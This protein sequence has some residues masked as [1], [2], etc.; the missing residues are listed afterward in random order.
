MTRRPNKGV[1][2]IPTAPA[3]RSLLTSVIPRSAVD[4]RFSVASLQLRPAGIDPRVSPI[5][6]VE[7]V[8]HASDAP[9]QA[10]SVT[11]PSWMNGQPELP[12]PPTRGALFRIAHSEMPSSSPSPLAEPA[13]LAKILP[14]ILV[15]DDE[16]LY[17]ELIADVL[18]DDYEILVAA[19]GITGL[20]IAA[21]RVPHLILLDLKIPGI[22]GFE[23]CKCLK[24]DQR[25]CDIA[26]IFITGSGDVAAETKG[27]QM[28]A[29]DYITKPLNPE[30]V[31]ARVNMQINFKLM[32][33]KL[34]Q[35]AAT[36]GLTGLANRF[37]FDNMLAYEYD[38][39]LRA[40]NELSLIMLDIDRFK[41][42]NDTY[43]HVQGDECLRE[44]ARALA[45][46]VSRA[47]DLVARY[48]GEEF[49]VLL[50]ETPLKGA[51]M[52]AGKV[53]KSIIDLYMPHGHSKTGF[54]TA[55]LGVAAS[56]FFAGS[57][58]M[59]VVQEAD[60]QLYAAKAGG[61]DRVNFRPTDRPGL[62]TQPDKPNR[63]SDSLGQH[64]PRKPRHLTCPHS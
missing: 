24:A 46:T 35:L 13:P 29:V 40:G 51:V 59:D 23:V 15:I 36:D 52:L 48:G 30:L 17:L 27:L 1:S 37:H 63:N 12:A 25:T 61:R 39:H 60:I 32:R 47:T 19:E 14:C 53:R 26:V 6:E 5:D 50:P 31:K 54:V 45:R 4:G 43:G 44:I 3:I 56:R 38:R 18:G 16:P 22:D 57:S 34:A 11:R 33:D 55:S 42:F 9:L 20:E 7:A 21:D 62:T 10:T 49:I 8:P 64:A 41:S 2:R 28:G 58:I